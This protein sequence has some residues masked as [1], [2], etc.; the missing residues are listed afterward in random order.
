[1]IVEVPLPDALSY[2]KITITED[3]ER[4]TVIYHLARGLIPL[5]VKAALL[6][7]VE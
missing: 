6:E 5:L 1:V 3:Y 4:E 7:E 2:L